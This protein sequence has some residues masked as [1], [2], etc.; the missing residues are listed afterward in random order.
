MPVLIHGSG[1]RVYYSPEKPEIHTEYGKIMVKDI[2]IGSAVKSHIGEK[3]VAAEPAISDIVEGFRMASRPIYYNDAGMIC[4]LLDVRPGA[5]V[6][7]A[8]TGSGGMS[9][10]MARN[11]G[12]NVI[13]YERE[14]R[15]YEIAKH[16][17]SRFPNVDLRHGDVLKAKEKD[18]DAVMLDLQ[19][20][21]KYVPRL[22]KKL[23]LGSFMGVYTPIM[24]DIANVYRAME[25]NFIARRII[26]VDL[27]ELVVKKYARVQGMFGFP[28]F[29]IWGRRFE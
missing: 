23:K 13:T 20:P 2:N 16:N 7:E 3:F 25:K 26:Q 1:K 17:L 28:G 18:F 12:A 4:G 19:N 11:C 21:D 22:A 15:F 10:F 6:L 14:E 9:A 24:D 5:R 27:K 29:F 8:G